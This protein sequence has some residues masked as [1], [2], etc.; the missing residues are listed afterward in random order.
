MKTSVSTYSFGEYLNS[1]RLG[2]FGVIDKA[3]EMGFDGIEFAEAGWINGYDFSLAE[4]IKE[5]VASKNMEVVSYCVGAD[6][7]NGSGGV[8]KDEINRLCRISKFAAALGA[9]H[10]RHDVAG[11][12]P[13]GKKLGVSYDVMIPR[14][15]E[16]CREVSKFAE[17]IGIGTMTENHGN[18]SQDSVRVE[19]LINETNY[20][21]FTALID[22]GNF[23]CVDEDPCQAVGR[24]IPYCKYVVHVK[25]FF[26]KSGM[27]IYPGQG[28]FMTRAG[29]YLRGTIVGHGDAKIYQSIQKLKRAEF[30]GFVSIEFEG[31][32]DNLKG[33][34]LGLEN[35][36]RFIG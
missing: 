26:W 27:E 32:E 16:G 12:G 34:R 36:K 22:A 35:L 19:K 28:W 9:K 29:N 21:N 5:Y 14:L 31:T 13:T 7:I 10:M 2:I 33:I 20:D 6:F 15:A 23:M 8:L 17:Q 25:D 18:Y 3:A 30:D 1:D 11:C 24:M 4:K